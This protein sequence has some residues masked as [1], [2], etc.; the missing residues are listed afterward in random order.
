VRISTNSDSDFPCW[1]G[2]VSTTFAVDQLPVIIEFQ[3]HIGHGLL[4]RHQRLLE[5]RG[6]TARGA[7]QGLAV[8]AGGGPP[9]V[10]GHLV[11]QEGLAQILEAVRRAQVVHHAH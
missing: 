7:A 1:R 11:G 3:R 5:G 4:P 8:G 9:W 6:D 10:G 2:T